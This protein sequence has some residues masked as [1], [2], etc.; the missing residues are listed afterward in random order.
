MIGFTLINQ[1]QIGFIHDSKTNFIDPM[2]PQHSRFAH[3]DVPLYA[4]D[5]FIHLATT[6]RGSNVSNLLLGRGVDGVKNYRKIQ[7]V[8]P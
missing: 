7:G 4:S 3:L 5:V 2:K 1:S 6:G 8:A